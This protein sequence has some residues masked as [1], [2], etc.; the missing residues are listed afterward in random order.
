MKKLLLL[1]SVLTVC[2]TISAEKNIPLQMADLPLPAQ[3]FINTY[4]PNAKATSVILERS[5]LKMKYKVVLAS[6]AQIDF[7][8][9]G[10]WTEVDCGQAAVP[11]GI[12]E[13]PIVSIAQDWFPNITIT[14]V[15]K[16]RG[17]TEITLSNGA[18]MKFNKKLN[19]IDIDD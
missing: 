10:A 7:N 18:E 13:A 4:F 19:V 5:T 16:D 14:Q 9:K 1:F 6:G 11:A 8:R 2:L 3:T 12:V 17:H 15:E